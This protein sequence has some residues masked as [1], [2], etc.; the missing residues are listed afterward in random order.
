MPQW[1]WCWCESGLIITRSSSS[2]TGGG[3]HRL[4]CCCCHTRYDASGR[5]SGTGIGQSHSSAMGTM[6]LWQYH[7]SIAT[8]AIAMVRYQLDTNRTR[9]GRTILENAAMGFVTI[10]VINNNSNNI[11]FFCTTTDSSNRRGGGGNAINIPVFVLI[12]CPVIQDLDFRQR[13]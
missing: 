10:H 1:W 4:Q 9:F 5:L 13:K 6:V 7:L 2:D 12:W 8:N 3:R 11:F